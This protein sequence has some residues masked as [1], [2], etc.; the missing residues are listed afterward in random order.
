MKFSQSLLYF[1]H[2]ELEDLR[3]CE[4]KNDVGKYNKMEPFVC[5]GSGFSTIYIACMEMYN[6]IVV[7]TYTIRQKIDLH[8]HGSR[9][10]N[11]EG[12]IYYI[13]RIFQNFPLVVT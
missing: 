11:E 4:K 3:E 8:I 12:K 13:K 10:Y 5:V 2:E 6:A 7:H 1:Q 9:I